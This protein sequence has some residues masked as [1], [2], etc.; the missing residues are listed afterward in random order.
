MRRTRRIL[1]MLGF[2]LAGMALVAAAATSSSTTTAPVKPVIG[3]PS[4]APT[5]PVAGMRLTVVFPVTRADTGAPLMRGRMICDPSIG[6]RA[7]RHVESFV[8][9][10]ARLSLV[11]P[12]NAAGRLLKVKV[13]IRAGRSSTR[14]ATFHV[15]APVTPSLSIGDATVREGNAGTTALTLPVT[16]SPAATRTVSVDYAAADGTAVAP[17]DYAAASGTLTFQPG[18]TAKSIAIGVVGEATVEPNETLTVALSNPVNA[19]LGRSAATGTIT[20]DDTAVPVT[21]GE[22]KGATR[23]GNYVFF[24]VLPSRAVTRFRVNDL[25]QRCGGV[26]TSGGEDLGDSVYP[27]AKYGRF[28]GTTSWTGSVVEG[29]VEWTRRDTSLTGVFGSATSATGTI[30]VTTEMNYQGRHYTCRSG[31]VSWSA[32]FH[33]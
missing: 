17:S 33:G 10:K 32:T 28:S 29:D 30:T 19:V 31:T 16:L 1:V 13:T 18:E 4:T 20:N 24:T 12:A 21:P 15:R 8:G 27:I 2:G 26:R 25:P 23:I 14:V 3:K 7:I 9:G 11:V 22:Y 6:R 5:Q